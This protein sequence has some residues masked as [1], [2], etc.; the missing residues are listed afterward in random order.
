MIILMQRSE[1]L[2]DIQTIN[3]NGKITADLIY[4]DHPPR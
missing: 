3:D 1:E 2:P 4:K